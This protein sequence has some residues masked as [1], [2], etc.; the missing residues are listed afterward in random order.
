[1]STFLVTGSA[2]TQ[3]L[4]FSFLAVAK[5]IASTRLR[6]D[7]QA[8]LALGGLVKYRDMVYPQMVTHLSTNPFQANSAFHP[9]GVGK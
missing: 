1:M 3:N 9:F 4:P 5:T 7:D 2:V 6:R 8:E